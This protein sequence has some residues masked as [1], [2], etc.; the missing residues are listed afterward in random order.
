[1]DNLIAAKNLFDKLLT[2]FEGRADE[3]DKKYDIELIQKAL[4]LAATAGATSVVN[5][6]VKRATIGQF[7]SLPHVV[8]YASAAQR[9]FAAIVA[10]LKEELGFDVG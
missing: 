5:D 2:P 4:D 1:M 6:L 8:S 10:K 9:E 7:R 3:L